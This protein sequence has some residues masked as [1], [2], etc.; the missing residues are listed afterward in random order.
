MSAY[1]FIHELWRIV[2]ERANQAKLE[3]EILNSTF[4]FFVWRYVA[5]QDKQEQP[6]LGQ[7]TYLC[8]G[9]RH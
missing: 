6:Y 7:F 4:I 9:K 3:M 8:H 5:W 2:N 1:D